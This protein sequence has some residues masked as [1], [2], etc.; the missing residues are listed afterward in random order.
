MKDT[1][2]THRQPNKEGQHGCLLKPQYKAE[3]HPYRNIRLGAIDPAAPLS[4]GLS[5]RRRYAKRYSSRTAIG[6]PR[7]L[8]PVLLA[9][10]GSCRHCSE[11]A[12]RCRTRMQAL[13][14]WHKTADTRR[15]RQRSLL[16]HEPRA[17]TTKTY[18]DK[19]HD[20]VV[21]LEVLPPNDAHTGKGPQGD[22]PHANEE[23]HNGLNHRVRA[24][25]P[26]N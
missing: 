6:I 20:V 7:S 8:D 11:N 14:R 2:E 21:A 23:E 9:R 19:E 3:R 24:Q 13:F 26:V 18:R 1:K 10:P 4:V 17:T 25:Q 16:R 12:S 5:V 22:Y 15:L